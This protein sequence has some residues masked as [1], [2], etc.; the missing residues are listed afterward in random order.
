MDGVSKLRVMSPRSRLGSAG[1]RHG[2]VTVH[3]LSLGPEMIG[4]A[5]LGTA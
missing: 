1:T 5:I 3:R 2:S 4:S